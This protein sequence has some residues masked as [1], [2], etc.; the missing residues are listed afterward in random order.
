MVKFPFYGWLIPAANTIASA[1][2][3]ALPFGSDT[4]TL[5]MK[6]PNEHLVPGYR[7]SMEQYMRAMNELGHR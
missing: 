6:W 5:S 3:L 7:A 1:L 2:A 4:Q